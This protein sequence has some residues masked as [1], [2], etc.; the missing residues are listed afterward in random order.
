[1]DICVELLYKAASVQITRLPNLG[2]GRVLP[3]TA[4][5]S[6]T[7]R[8]ASSGAVSGFVHTWL[9]LTALTSHAAEHGALHNSSWHL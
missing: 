9:A 3:G 7:L 2:L 8:L 6:L 5:R 1:M 4:R